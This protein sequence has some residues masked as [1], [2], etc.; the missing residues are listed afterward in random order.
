MLYIIY[1]LWK[2]Y[3]SHLF[4]KQSINDYDSTDTVNEKKHGKLTGMFFEAH[5][6][7]IL[8]GK[9]VV[10]FNDILNSFTW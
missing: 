8:I 9:I 2:W 4:N 5:C 7:Y 6:Q 3:S 10:R 1:I